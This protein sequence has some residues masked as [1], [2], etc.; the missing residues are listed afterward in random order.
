VGRRDDVIATATALLRESG[1]DALTSVN[2]AQRLGVT[3]SAIYRHVHDMD[4]VTMIASRNIVDELSAVV[5]A[6]VA[7]PEPAW[8]QGTQIANI[9][10]RIIELI[11]DHEQA[12]VAIGRWRYCD[13]ALGEGI[14]EILDVGVSHIAAEFESAWRHDFGCDTAFDEA[15]AAAQ[16]VH[17]ELVVDDVIAVV[18]SISAAGPEHRQMVA[19]TLGLRL[20]AGWCAYVVDVNTRMGVPIPVLGG[21]MLSSPNHV[22]NHSLG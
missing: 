2:I 13:D 14:R 11:D 3:Q 21:P 1:P 10:T 20:F 15:T 6:A 9:A 4:E 12:V 7:S 17:A 22:P 19:R 8:A 18:R 16:R 5:I